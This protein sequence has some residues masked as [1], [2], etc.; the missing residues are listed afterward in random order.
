MTLISILIK[1]HHRTIHLHPDQHP[2]L[3]FPLSLVLPSSFPPFSQP[4]SLRVFSHLSWLELL[5]QLGL[6]KYLF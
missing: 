4:S 6:Q 3:L 5:L 1:N 2:L